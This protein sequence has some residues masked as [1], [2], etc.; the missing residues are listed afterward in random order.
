MTD[1]FAPKLTDNLLPYDG[2]VNDL[3]I[4]IDYPSP[5]FYNLVTELPW[6]EDIVTLFGKTHITTRQIVWMGDS[7]I[8]YQYSGHT[9]Q[10]IPWTDTVFHVKHHIEQKLLDLG[11]DANFNS[12]LLNYYPSG[13]DGM[14]YHADDERELGEQPVIASLSLGAT[15]KFVFKHK[16]TQDKVELYLESGQLIVM[17]GDT[18]SFWKHSITKTKKVT[19]GRISL[20]F[21]Q[22]YP[23]NRS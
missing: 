21:R 14:G 11:I 6:Q 10:T 4:V 9:R 23:N 13:E 15:R 17:H 20:T 8:D 16:K 7:D 3:G 5:L 22:I 2:L 18:Q 12:C 1:I 19:T